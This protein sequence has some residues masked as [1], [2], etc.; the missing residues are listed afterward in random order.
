[1]RFTD[2]QRPRTVAKLEELMTAARNERLQIVHQL[3]MTRFDLLVSEDRLSRAVSL[4]R[5]LGATEEQIEEAM[6]P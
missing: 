2:E 1:M 6:N 5:H 4:L 3:E